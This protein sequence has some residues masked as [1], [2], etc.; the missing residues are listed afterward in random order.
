MEGNA[1]LSELT[2]LSGLVAALGLPPDA[3][4][5]WDDTVL[6]QWAP[7]MGIAPDT[8]SLLAAIATPQHSPR[9]LPLALVGLARLVPQVTAV[10]HA[11]PLLATWQ[12]SQF[13]T[14]P[15][16]PYATFAPIARF[17]ALVSLAL[18]AEAAGLILLHLHVLNT[19]TNTERHGYTLSVAAAHLAEDEAAIALVDQGP[20]HWAQAVD[21]LHPANGVSAATLSTYQAALQVALGIADRSTALDKSASSPA[22]VA[23]CGG[24]SI[25]NRS[26]Q[27]FLEA[28]DELSLA[29][30]L[31][32]DPQRPP[33]R[34][35]HRR[36]GGLTTTRAL[37]IPDGLGDC[38]PLDLA[39]L[40]GRIRD[41]DLD[42]ANK[43]VLTAVFVTMFV[44]GWPA[45]L[46]SAI[47]PD[48]RVQL[49]P[50][51]GLIRIDGA[52]YPEWVGVH[53]PFLTVAIDPD[54]ATRLASLLGES[55]SLELTL[56][57]RR[58]PLT[59]RHL[60]RALAWLNRDATIGVWMSNLRGAIWHQARHGAWPPE[61]L[62]LVTTQTDPFLHQPFHYGAFPQPL[63]AADL[64]AT[65]RAAAEDGWRERRHLQ[66]AFDGFGSI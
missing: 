10:S 12:Q 44:T 29:E 43:R 2:T 23:P 38:A 30:V 22:S 27:A 16:M 21:E 48:G 57:G 9:G 20:T 54:L 26:L 46:F 61:V 39:R 7:S 34:A 31:S 37:G 42:P 13:T 25:A 14:N 15:R 49:D 4:P 33:G 36:R 19:R 45:A 55:G 64:H 58:R 53:G 28:V 5:A 24:P 35:G 1:P 52:F 47:G 65:M 41:S 66:R 3:H 59:A 62:A 40:I 51:Q 17:L 8:L 50:G 63:E 11:G 32:E 60:H 6:R 18:P 56:R